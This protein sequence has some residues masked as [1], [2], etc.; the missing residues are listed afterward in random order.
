MS[1][2]KLIIIVNKVN[3]CYSSR[4]LIYKENIGVEFCTA[5]MRCCAMFQC[6]IMLNYPLPF[7]TTTK[8]FS[9]YVMFC[10]PP[11]VVHKKFKE[12]PRTISYLM[13]HE[14]LLK[15]GELSL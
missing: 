15:D 14:T 2:F 5:K 7:R 9:M 10:S 11:V 12:L 3:N 4:E 13:L 8:L 1:F 6:L